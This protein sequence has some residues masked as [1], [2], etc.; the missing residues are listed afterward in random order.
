MLIWSYVES[1]LVIVELWL[2]GRIRDYL[3]WGYAFLFGVFDE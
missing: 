2:L 1:L 3:K